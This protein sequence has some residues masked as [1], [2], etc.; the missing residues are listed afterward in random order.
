MSYAWWEVGN[1][2]ALRNQALSMYIDNELR[3]QIGRQFSGRK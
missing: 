1:Y 2:Q 3:K